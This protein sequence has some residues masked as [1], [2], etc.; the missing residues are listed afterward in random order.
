MSSR[1]LISTRKGLFEVVQ[2][3]GRWSLRE[4]G[5]VGEPVSAALYDR[6]DG[7]TYAALN[8]GHFGV[9]L[10]RIED[11]AGTWAEIAVP[12]YPARAQRGDDVEWKLQMI[13]SLAAGGADEPGVLWAG[14]L[15]GGLFRSP[16]RGQSWELVRALWDEPSR[17]EWFGGG[18]DVPGIHSICVDPRDA[19]RVL[20]GISCGG[21]WMSRDGGASWTASVSGMRAAYM[22]PERAEDPA[23]QDPHLIA[24]CAGAPD[25]Y[26]CQH[27]NG[28]WRSDDGAAS[29]QE[30]G[31]A[32]RPLVSDFGF[33]VAVHPADPLTA[34][35]VPAVA[36]QKRVPKDAALC[37]MR[38]RDGGKTFEVLRE[39]LPQHHCYDL[40]YRHG[41]AVADDGRTLLMGSTTGGLWVSED[42]AESWHALEAR[43][44][45]IH[46]VRFC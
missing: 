5:F 40:V 13:W 27:H 42:A 7:A 31:P 43:L 28:I 12:A 15:P 6:R 41:L 25:V 2:D 11:G 46:A 24:Q 30:I 39:G 4:A 3:A 9:K 36:D 44:P 17:R 33:A 38:T 35:F 29:W 21:A 1:A 22:P 8:L 37:V 20:V 23:V 26:W 18:Y 19:R 10:H 45:P 32:A 34:W 14:T 16:D